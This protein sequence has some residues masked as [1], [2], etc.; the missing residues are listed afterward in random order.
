MADNKE[1]T[2]VITLEFDDGVE[3]EC[4]IIGTFDY[5]D[6]EFIALAPDDDSGEVFIYAYTETED[7][8][9]IEEIEDDEKFEA[10]VAEF[11]SLVEEVEE[12]E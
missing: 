7:G 11:E 2:D 1:Q 8:F 4:E 12:E 10:V 3:L 5:E 9:E 6:E